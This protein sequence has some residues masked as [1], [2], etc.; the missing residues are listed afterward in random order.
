M[1]PT[2]F[3]DTWT[4][5]HARLLDEGDPARRVEPAT[6]DERR[7]MRATV[8]SAAA[9]PRT[10]PRR[11]LLLPLAAA[12]AALAV[13]ALLVRDRIAPPESPQSSTVAA[14]PSAPA[15]SEAPESRQILFSTPGG[16]RIVWILAPTDPF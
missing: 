16:T 4:S 1:R 2:R 15:G 12:L 10:A 6:P 8:L 14:V 7:A 9:E 3:E 11:P 5:E 13:G